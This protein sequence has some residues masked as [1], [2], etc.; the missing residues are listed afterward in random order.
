MLS[1]K[2]NNIFRSADLRGIRMMH[3]GI[4]GDHLDRILLHH[5]K[6]ILSDK[7]KLKYYKIV[8]QT[9]V[10]KPEKLKKGSDVIFA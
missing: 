5:W 3:Q 9:E 10:D 7:E 4:E 2:Q 1:T 6:N 8:R